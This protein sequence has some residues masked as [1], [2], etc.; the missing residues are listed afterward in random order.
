MR[1]SW[2]RK[3]GYRVIDKSGMMR[4]LGNHLLAMRFLRV[5]SVIR[6]NLNFPLASLPFLFLKTA[7]VR[8]RML[9]MKG[10]KELLPDIQT[11]LK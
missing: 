4:L 6:K 10:Q 9:Y 7:G 1:A 5:S 2:F 11:G 8:P 3:Q